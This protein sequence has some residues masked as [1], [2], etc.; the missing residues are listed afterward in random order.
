MDPHLRYH[1][2]LSNAELAA[3][4]ARLRV[5]WVTAYR[6]DRPVPSP[7]PTILLAALA[8]SDEARLRLTLIPLCLARPEYA[9]AVVEAA[10]VVPED[11]WVTLACYY[12]AAVSLQQK[13][14]DRLDQLGLKH[15][16]L[17]DQFARALDLPIAGDPDARL[18][19]LAKRQGDLSGRSLNWY[20]TYEHA[21]ERY[22][23]RAQ[24]ELAWAAN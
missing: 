21:A 15:D 6:S 1:L 19:L 9:H 23:R 4:L 8:S 18:R 12:S 24:L 13:Y 3:E 2:R 11:A 5:N 17:P 7:P 16:A 14:G 22:I 10:G 20:G